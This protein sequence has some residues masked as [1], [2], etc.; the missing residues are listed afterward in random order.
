MKAFISTISAVVLG[1]SSL[2]FVSSAQAD[3]FSIS[4]IDGSFS[5]S[6]D[7]YSDSGYIDPPIYIVNN[8]WS[9]PPAYYDRH[10]GRKYWRHGK[11]HGHRKH[12][13]HKDRHHRYDR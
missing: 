1:I 8:T 12:G 6:D 10:H 2:G 5:Y 4:I 13:H 9:S 7:E 11:H 3:S